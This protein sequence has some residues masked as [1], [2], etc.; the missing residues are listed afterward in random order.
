[1]AV[2]GHGLATSAISLLERADE[3]EAIRGL[4]TDAA[5]GTSGIGV[6]RGPPGAGK[7]SLLKAARS[8]AHDRGLRVLSARG[9]PH[10]RDYAFAAVRQLLGPMVL[11][12]G[13]SGQE[14]LFSGAARHAQ[15]VFDAPAGDAGAKLGGDP[16]YATLHGLFWL[17]AGIAQSEPLLVIVDD[18]HWCDPPSGRFLSFLSRR[19][20]GLTV[21]LLLAERSGED[22]TQGWLAE[23]GDDPSTRVITP[24]PLSP[25]AITAIAAERINGEPDEALGDA[26]WQATGGNPFFVTAALDELARDQDPTDTRVSRLRELG[27]EAVL[28]SVL[29]RLARLPLGAVALAHAVAVLGDGATLESAAGLGQL[30]LAEAQAAAD[31]LG[32]IGVLTTRRDVVS[33]AHPI[34]RNALYRDLTPGARRALHAD[35][36]LMLTGAGAAPAQVAIHL[37]RSPSGQ[38]GAA[39]T[40]ESAAGAALLQGAPQVAASY[41]RRALEEPADDERRARLLIDLGCAEAQAGDANA[42]EHLTDGLRDTTDLGR[43]V[44]AAIT[45]A[46]TLAANERTA[47][48]VRIL[49]D[50]GDQLSES[51]PKLAT[52]VFSELVSLGD[53]IARPLVPARA[54][55]LA[56]STDPAG[57][58]HRAVELTASA[59][60]AGEASALAQSALAGGE[61]LARGDAVF[62]FACAMLIYTESF[63]AA[64]NFLDQALCG[65]AAGGSAPAFISAS[66]QRALLN[67][68]RGALL[69]AE[70]DARAA[71]EASELLGGQLWQAHTLTAL[72]DVLL[73]RGQATQAAT[74]LGRAL[75]S[76]EA[77]SGNQG[78][79]LLEARGRLRLELG[80]TRAAVTDLLEAGSRLEEWGLHNPSVAAWRSHAALGL[81]DLGDHQRAA[82]LVKDEVALARRW[83]TPRALGVAVRAQALVANDERT[84]PLLQEA[85]STL[86]RSQAPVEHARAL[87]DLGAALRRTNQRTQA[88]EHLGAALD[89]ALAAGAATVA[90][91]AHTELVAT[92]V[93]PR[94]PLRSGVDALTP[95]ERRIAQMAASGQTNMTI[96]QTL[97]VT[98]K[99]VEMHLTSTYRKLDIAS[100]THLAEAM[101]ATGSG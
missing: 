16:A 50:L 59:N 56:P 28:R 46:H 83:G 48:S 31:G 34:V 93:R 72:I 92:G 3:L 35:A 36:A 12:A 78:A 75:P 33:F 29:I 7:T 39:G 11:A 8:D 97:F 64:K 9:S 20:E 99:T 4:I 37:L 27:P 53:L 74:E 81:A 2:S 54:R 66:G 80:E 86:A 38:K 88:R 101:S 69:E 58:T 22:S 30:P 76:H 82:D 55:R 73:A 63:E 49:S 45:L 5:E 10:E 77:P 67:T 98:I 60:C 89:T 61:L 70:A 62:A 6:V 25:Q 79:L 26:C 47:E 41:L 96:A 40:L 52:R 57:L 90:Q 71:L 32:A 18:A 95:S 17:L 42:V 85:C 91:R 68:R 51:D 14:R 24:L 43:R 21:A 84:V 100:R 23:L 44:D 65:A 87:T 1:M 15:L 13:A 94:T 19:L